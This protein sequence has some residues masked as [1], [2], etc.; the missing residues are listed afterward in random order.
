MTASS[1][2]D[3]VSTS[4]QGAAQCVVREVVVL[5]PY[6]LHIQPAAAL[7][8]LAGKF[9][10]NLRL[11]V[12]GQSFGT[13]SIL[14]LLAANLAFR[15][16]ATLIA[17]GSDAGEAAEAVARFLAQQPHNAAESPASSLAEPVLKR[18]A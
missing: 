11:V 18:V 6:G 9:T 1:D 2:T 16:R 3:R 12:D 13:A 17:E 5:K 14:D 4:I 7:V 10:S 8:E 15:K